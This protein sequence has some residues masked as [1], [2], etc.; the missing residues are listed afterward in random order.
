MNS[1]SA[2]LRLEP[3]RSQQTGPLHSPEMELDE[4]ETGKSELPEGIVLAAA[5][6]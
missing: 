5:W 6:G 4:N 2:T 3:A 1:I